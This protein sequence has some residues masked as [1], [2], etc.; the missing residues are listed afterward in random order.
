MKY[1]LSKIITLIMVGYISLGIGGCT[2]NMKIEI[3][4]D[5]FDFSVLNDVAYYLIIPNGE[6]S[7]LEGHNIA[8]GDY[9]F[10]NNKLI[11]LKE[12]LVNLLPGKYQ[13][14]VYTTSGRAQIKV[15]VK[16]LKQKYRIVNGGFETGNLFGWQVLTVFK[17]EEAIQSFVSAGIKKNTVFSPL[18]TFYN[19]D[20]DYVYGFDDRS[21]N[22]DRWNERMGIMRSRVF[23]LG[24]SGFITFKL[25]GAKNQDLCYVSIRE[26]DS[27][28]EI[29]RYSNTQF[30]TTTLNRGEYFGANLVTYK[31]DLSEYLGKKLYIEIADFGGRDWDFITCD[32]FE[33]YH[34]SEPETGIWAQD[35]KP[36]FDQF[37][38][39][40]Q[41]PNGDFSCGLQSW[42]VSSHRGWNDNSLDNAFIV[43]NNVLKSNKNGDASRGLIRSSLFRIDGSGIISLKIGAAQGE[44]FDKD[45]FISIKEEKT[46]FEIVRIANIRSDG[47]NLIKYYINLEDYKGKNCYIEIVDNACNGYDT[48]FVADIITYYPTAPEYNYGQAGIN[49]NY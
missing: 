49:L 11:I 10:V 21:S 8:D 14:N 9:L 20:G 30:N 27:S 38:I 13:F 39:P 6:F 23:E 42:Q 32:S 41:L 16:D 31:A 2:R 3:I 34:L 22:T 37:F 45:T 18:E 17:G 33:T 12:Y 7:H 26:A 46:N 47:I 35:I 36:S 5:V 15:E 44:R 19:G 24:G 48:I 4:D 29:A 40:N 28:I 43:D 1:K 25:G